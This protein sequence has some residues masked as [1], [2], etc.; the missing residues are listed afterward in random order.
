[1][2]G[3][4]P[5]PTALKL[6]DGN[7]GK[8]PLNQ[9]EPTLEVVEPACPDHLDEAARREWKHVV[10]IL[11]K[12]RVLTEADGA[13]LGIWCQTYSTLIDLQGRIAKTGTLYTTKKGGFVQ[14]NP[15]FLQML[16]CVN[17]IAKISAEF[18]LTPSA[19]VRLHATP[20]PESENKWSQFQKSG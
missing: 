12:M 4:P 13:M 19:R 7:P 17:V 10:P 15:L 9:L 20:D 5:K 8:R 14:T 3:P 18:G 16:K 11:M 1:M 2:K 6:L